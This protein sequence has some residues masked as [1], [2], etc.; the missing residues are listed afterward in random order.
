MEPLLF[1][2]VTVILNWMDLLGDCVLRMAPGAATPQFV[3]VIV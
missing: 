1:T 2:S 3:R